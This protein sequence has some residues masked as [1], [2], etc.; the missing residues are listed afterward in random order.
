MPKRYKDRIDF[1]PSLLKAAIGRVNDT[2]QPI[3]SDSLLNNTAMLYINTTA[4]RP[5]KA[6]VSEFTRTSGA[7]QRSYIKDFKYAVNSL[8][9]KI[10]ST[11]RFARLNSK[12]VFATLYEIQRQV[13]KLDVEVGETEIKM[14]NGFSKVHLNTFVRQMDS[15]LQYKDKSWITDFKTSF[16]YPKKYLMHLLPSSGV[17]L[18][19]RYEVSIPIVD[20]YIV[21]EFT[22]VGDTLMPVIS[23]SPRN[24]FIK[25]KIFKHILVRKNFDE[26][27]RKYKSKTLYDNYP[28]SATSQLTLELVMPNVCM[29]NY[30]KVN[31]VNAASFS[32]KDISYLNESGEQISIVSQSV[33]SDL[34][35]TFLFEPIYTKH[36]RVTFE[37]ASTVAKTTTTIGD[38]ERIALSDMLEGA[39]FSAEINAESKEITGRWYDFSI[40]DIEVGEIGYENKGIYRSKSIKTSSPLGFEIN[41]YTEAIT[42]E[43]LFS[44][45][46]K[47]VTLPEGKALSEAYVGVRLSNA[48]GGRVVDS[49]VPVPDSYPTQIEF[50]DFLHTDAR[51]KLFPDLE[52]HLNDNCVSS[53]SIKEVCVTLDDVV[54]DYE[55]EESNPSDNQESQEVAT[56]FNF[57]TRVYEGLVKDFSSSS[58]SDSAS[59]E[60]VDSCL[61]AGERV[62][63][64][65]RGG[66]KDIQDISIGDTVYTYDYLTRSYGEHIVTATLEGVSNGWLEIYFEG[67]EE[68]IRCSLSHHMINGEFEQIPAYLMNEGDC[69]WYLNHGSVLDVTEISEIIFHDEEVEVYNIE[70]EDAHTY[71]TSNGIL[72]HNKTY[73]SGSIPTITD[74]PNSKDFSNLEPA[75]S[76][77]VVEV[78]ATSG[79]IGDSLSW[80]QQY[81]IPTYRNLPTEN[82]V[83]KTTIQNQVLEDVIGSGYSSLSEEDKEQIRDTPELFN[84]AIGLNRRLMIGSTGK[85]AGYTRVKPLHINTENLNLVGRS[86]WDTKMVEV[87]PSIS[88]NTSTKQEYE[89]EISSSPKNLQNKALRHLSPKDRTDVKRVARVQN[90]ASKIRSI[91]PDRSIGAT[92]V[93][94]A[95]AEPGVLDTINE[96]VNSV[97]A[98]KVGYRVNE[99]GALEIAL[100]DDKGSS[101]KLY[102]KEYGARKENASFLLSDQYQPWKSFTL[103]Q[104]SEASLNI[105]KIYGDIYL[106]AKEVLEGVSDCI[107]FLSFTT[108]SPHTLSEG[109]LVTLTSSDSRFRGIYIVSYVEDNYTFY[110]SGDSFTEFVDG[111]GNFIFTDDDISDLQSSRICI[112][113]QDV[114]SPIELYEDD[115]LL[116]IGVDYSISLDD[117]STWYDYWLM[118]GEESYSYLNKRAKAGRFYVRVHNRNAHAIYW[119]KYRVKRNQSLSACEKI[120]LRNGRVVFDKALKNT[121]GTLQTVFIFRTNSTN[122]Y[123]TPILREYSLRVQE[124]DDS[125]V[126]KSNLSDKEVLTRSV[127]AKRN[128]S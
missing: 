7:T 107:D 32:I 41:R 27:S 12:D 24:V 84:Q 69:V 119:I 93:L 9:E 8:N 114:E 6:Y 10:N 112:W 124:R 113:A 98:P 35:A 19:R 83:G 1:L 75:I 43:Q 2:D 40:K 38:L 102:S 85:S 13:Y 49:I 70:V 103:D 17:T 74:I 30:L 3:E 122:P 108:E 87:K 118:P 92:D 99:R 36:L 64:N 18:P 63:V 21:D 52:W 96:F 109:D 78:K 28:Y 45:Y 123:I 26:T 65:D 4:M 120:R 77:S 94:Q 47:T 127:G 31:P 106:D 29:I 67:V 55:S 72:Q 79:D 57:P 82:R 60:P 89:V 5:P 104:I 23:T 91:V 34:F 15:Q 117:K 80:K 33:D 128:V 39:G 62:I 51:V 110:I 16:S 42:P 20:A 53:A 48:Q 56:D 71:I 100:V 44:E 116:K 58:S 68:P 121:F 54:P 101:N 97:F 22:D 126:N 76:G 61:L 73:G 115:R 66:S 86:Y 88:V 37:Q 125:G 105:T 111:E 14:L 81:A 25:N 90:L 46:Y 59:A 50:L 95:L 11:A